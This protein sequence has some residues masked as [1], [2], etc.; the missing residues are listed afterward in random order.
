[1]INE[2]DKYS[3]IDVNDVPHA[4]GSVFTGDS[5]KKSDFKEERDQFLNEKQL[6]HDVIRNF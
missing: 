4:E 3:D 5:F 6:Q 1:M 2:I